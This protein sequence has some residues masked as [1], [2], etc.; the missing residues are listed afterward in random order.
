MA[1]FF[2]FVL[3]FSHIPF[4]G[5][6]E[7]RID[8]SNWSDFCGDA[9]N[10]LEHVEVKV[11]LTYSLRGD[12]LIKLESPQGTVSNL[13]HYRFADSAYGFQ[14]LDWVLMSLHYWGENATG[15]W[16]LTLEN[17]NLDNYNT[18]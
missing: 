18:G 8:L 17:A 10:F 11:D 5:K 16:R 6:L 12:L 13:T 4:Q 7:E 2:G 9:I 15:Q 1:D 14:D 3:F